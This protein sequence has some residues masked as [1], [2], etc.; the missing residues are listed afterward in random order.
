MIKEI[1]LNGI[2]FKNYG[3]NEI[4]ELF[5]QN[6]L[7]VLPSG[8][9]LSNINKDKI[10]LK[11][12][13]NS[14]QVLLDSGYFVLLLK[15]LKNISVNKLSGYL[16]FTHLVK[17]L[18]KKKFKKLL[19]IDPN[20][21]FS[22]NNNNFF[23]KKGL[24]KKKIIHYI[25]PKY[26]TLR[27][28]DLKLLRLIKENK[29]DY[30]IIN[31][32]GGVQEILGYYLKR[33]SNNKIKIFCTG[34]AISYFTGDQAPLSKSLDN[35]YLGWL[36]RIFYNPCLIFRYIKAFKLFLIVKNSKIIV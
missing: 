28:F 11:A 21:K 3:K 35:Y 16:F 26:N 29:P 12:L 34:A 19:S 10:Y 13:R 32:G 25:A 27:L 7:I 24:D 14:D 31:I 23:V 22:K 9:G 5:D 17:H 20:H 2:H 30:I 1:I 4:D 6:G 18:Q 8:P 36:I 15:F 33:K